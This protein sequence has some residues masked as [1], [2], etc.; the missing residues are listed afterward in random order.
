MKFSVAKVLKK[1]KTA[2]II[3]HFNPICAII[4]NCFVFYN[5]K[6]NLFSQKTLQEEEFEQNGD[7]EEN[8][9]H[10][11]NFKHFRRFV[12][13]PEND[14]E[15]LLFPYNNLGGRDIVQCLDNRAQF[16][17]K[18]LGVASFVETEFLRNAYHITL[19]HCVHLKRSNR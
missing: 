18:F 16:G 14:G 4:E 9:K 1:D 6:F 2:I 5:R 10:R 8:E 7:C 15:Y 17:I 11:T 13:I 12:P 3:A 19:L